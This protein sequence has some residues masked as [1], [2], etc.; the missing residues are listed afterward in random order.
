[1]TTLP[2][3]A[4]S[5]SRTSGTTRASSRDSPLSAPRVVVPHLDTETIGQ[6]IAE[7]SPPGQIFFV[8][9]SLFSHGRRH[10]AAENS[11]PR[12]AG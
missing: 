8:T 7:H 6:A 9:E 5:F 3:R 10:R 11:T 1:M 2:E 4:I 12:S